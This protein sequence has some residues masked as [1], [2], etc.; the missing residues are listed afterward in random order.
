MN[1]NQRV[2]IPSHRVNGQSSFVNP[3]QSIPSIS[4]QGASVA[5]E[6]PATGFLELMERAC[7]YAR[8]IIKIKHSNTSKE[9]NDLSVVKK[10]KWGRRINQ[11][12]KD[13]PTSGTLYAAL[14]LADRAQMVRAGNC[15]E[16]AS[17]VIKY[18]TLPS[19]KC[20][21]SSDMYVKTAYIDEG[22]HVF[23]IA[24]TS[25]EGTAG[26]CYDHH[27]DIS[28]VVCDAWSGKCYFGNQIPKTLQDR[29]PM[30]NGTNEL[31]PF[32]ARSDMKEQKIKYIGICVRVFKNG[33]YEDASVDA[34]RMIDP[35]SDAEKIISEL[36]ESRK[37]L[38]IMGQSEWLPLFQNN[39]NMNDIKLIAKT[40]D[41]IALYAGECALETL[42][43]DSR[44]LTGRKNFSVIEYVKKVFDAITRFVNVKD[45]LYKSEAIVDIVLACMRHNLLDNKGTSELISQC[46]SAEKQNYT[47][48]PLYGLCEL[49]TTMEFDMCIAAM[50]GSSHKPSVNNKGDILSEVKAPQTDTLGKFGAFQSNTQGNSVAA[51]SEATGRLVASVTSTD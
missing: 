20:N 12:R 44:A 43:R 10:E 23:V 14:M 39:M 5:Q 11:M 30:D 36:G 37:Y 40:L 21:L 1:S 41:A 47:G 13:I 35:E 3:S 46:A 22:D 34:V 19:T 27:N 8:S 7:A 45:N 2:L 18:L 42:I 25:S 15:D 38:E 26:N 28:T 49:L 50:G 16:F 9:F 6:S 51:S 24:N 33:G 4:V 32:N 29:Y 31:R 17:L 48:S